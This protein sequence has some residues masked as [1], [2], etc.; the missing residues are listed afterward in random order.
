M[1]NAANNSKSINHTTKPGAENT[2][3][4]SATGGPKAKIGWGRTVHLGKEEYHIQTEERETVKNSRNGA[5]GYLKETTTP[6]KYVEY[7]TKR[8]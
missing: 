1:R 5:K 6:V 3:L 7:E 8:G 2:V 4:K